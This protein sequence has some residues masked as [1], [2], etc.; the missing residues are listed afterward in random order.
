MSK[1][2]ILSV[3]GARPDAV[4]MAPLIKEIA[5]YPDLF[6]NVVC[7]TGQH[8][9]MLDQVLN[10]FKIVPD[11]DLNIMQ[12]K[13]TFLYVA[14]KILENF[15]IVLEKENPDIVLVHGDT[16]TSFAAAFTAFFYKI[17]VGHVEAGLRSNDK[18][19]PFPEEM[20]RIL[21]G[22]IADLHFA[23]TKSNAVNLYRENIRNNV[24]ITGNTVIDAL[25]AFIKDDYTFQNDALQAIDFTSKKTIFMTM[26]RRENLGDPLKN[27]FL[28]VKHLAF[29]Y[30]EQIQIVY[31]VHKNPAVSEP[32]NRLLGNIDNIYLIDPLSVEDAHNLMNRCYFV[33]T[34]SGGLQEE[35]PALGKPV[36]VCRTETERPEAVEA[37]TAKVVGVSTENIYNEASVLI[38][39][40]YEYDKMAKAVNPYGDGTACAKI[41]KILKNYFAL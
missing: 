6:E 12:P 26:H 17:P 8:R 41:V 24:Y 9:E 30:R 18:Y 14:A 29:Q 37:G 25:R 35:A 13:Q 2:K 3:F 10:S 39:N 5:K 36:L 33:L 15:N 32:A 1:K 22:D 38:E 11:Y 21:T 7:V 27:I 4:K 28:A 34:D 31:S 16:T 20:N 40:K 19:S 23:P